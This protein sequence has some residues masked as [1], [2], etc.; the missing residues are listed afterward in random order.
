MVDRE[1]TTLRVYTLSTGSG[2]TP[3]PDTPWRV[4]GTQAPYG[5]V[6]VQNW[7]PANLNRDGCG[8]LVHLL[9]THPGVRVEYLL[10]NC[11]GTW[12]SSTTPDYFS[13]ATATRRR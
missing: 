9:P 4:N 2:W 13:T 11:D 12:T 5:S 7:R 1:G 8:D 6:D 10:S 3:K